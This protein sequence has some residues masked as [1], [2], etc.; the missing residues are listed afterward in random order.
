MEEGAIM[1]RATLFWL[2]LSLMMGVLNVPGMLS[3]EDYGRYD[4]RYERNDNWRERWRNTRDDRRDLEGS[5]YLG[6]HRDLRA[7]IALTRRGLEATNEHGHTTRLEITRSGNVHALDWEGGLRGNVRRDR[8][9][10]ENGT[11]WMRQPVYRYLRLH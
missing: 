9:E 10:W 4:R 7:E 3:A 11:T 1:K 6:G 5:W 2:M 8:I